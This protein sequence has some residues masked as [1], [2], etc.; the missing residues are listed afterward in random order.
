LSTGVVLEY[1][2]PCRGDAA[3][4]GLVRQR[5]IRLQLAAGRDDAARR[6]PGLTC[7]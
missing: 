3:G 1:V 5:I 6:T 7:G 2:A 4:Q